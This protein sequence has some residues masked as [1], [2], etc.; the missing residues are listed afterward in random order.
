MSGKLS[1]TQQGGAAAQSH[2]YCGGAGC[3]TPVNLLGLEPSEKTQTVQ[4]VCAELP[5]ATGGVLGVESAKKPL[6]V[7]IFKHTSVPLR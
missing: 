3:L 1:R 7:I 4:A 2:W 5:E 6:W